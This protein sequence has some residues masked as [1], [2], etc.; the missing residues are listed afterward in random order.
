MNRRDTLAALLALAAAAA[1]PR[2]LLGQTPKRSRIGLLRSSSAPTATAPSPVQ[3]AFRDG[4]RAL[5]YVEGKNYVIEARYAD[6]SLERLSALAVELVQ[7]RVDLILV[8]ITVEAAAAKKATSS[9]PI[10]MAA[11]ADPIR[12]GLVASLAR[13]GGNVTGLTFQTPDIVG[14]RLELLK[15]AVPNVKR[16]GA[17]H[18]ASRAVPIVDRWVRDNEA[19]A[20]AL[21]LAL[22]PVETGFEPRAWDEVFKEARARGIGAVTAMDSSTF[23][24]LRAQLAETAL[25]HRMPT[26]SFANQLVEAGGLMSYGA[27]PADLWRRAA[28]YVDKILKGADPRDLPVEQPTRFYLVVNLKTARALGLTIPPSVMIRADHVIQ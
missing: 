10:V 5:G 15:E 8:G 17:F 2:L 6:R 4:M 18:P 21:G 9:I 22:D 13:P 3:E 16:V 14:K 23:F 1:F 7:A 25:R 26:M 28:V 24:Q 11:A 20:Q 19:A 27:D 12:E